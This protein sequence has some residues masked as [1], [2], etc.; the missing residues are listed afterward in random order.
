MTRMIERWFPCA[1]VS[2]RSE[3]G[4]GS[5]NQERALFSWFAARPAAQ[6]KAAVLCSLLPW[7]DSPE[8]QA[9]LR[10][11]VHQ[12]MEDR[13]ASW[14]EV[15]REL[16]RDSPG[17]PAV[18]DPF[19]GRGMIPLEAARLGLDSLAVDYSPVAV[20]ASELLTD[21]PFRD[22]SSE[23]DIAWSRVEERLVDDRPRLLRDVEAVL[24]QVGVRHAAT[25]A[26]FYPV[27][28]GTPPWGYLWAVTLPC[29]ECTRRF[30]LVASLEL[31]K[32]SVRKNR[33]T[34]RSFQDP[35][36]A[37]YLKS[38]ASSDEFQVIVHD[39]PPERAPT[40]ANAIGP[41]G[42]KV[43]GKSATCCFCGH[44]HPL[45]VHQRLAREGLGRDALIAVVSPD[46]LVGRAFR[47]PTGEELVAAYGAADALA[48]EPSFGPG[49]PPLPDEVIPANN[50]ATIRP[51]L[52]GASSYGDLM[53]DRQT[54]STIRLCRAINDVAADL[55]DQGLSGDYRR[56]LIGYAGATLVRVLK[57]S[58]R[59]AKMR[60]TLGAGLVDHIFSNE[61]TVGFSYD[62][63]EV[64]LSDGPGSWP[65]MSASSVSTLRS[66][67]H[68]APPGIPTRVTRGS[69]AALPFRDQAVSAVV[70]DPPYDAMV[71][72]SDSSDL[73][74]AWLKRALAST[75]PDLALSANPDGTQDKSEEIIVKEHGRAPGE[76]RTREHYDAKIAQAFREMRR[77]VRTDGVVTIVFGSGDPVVWQRLL[78]ALQQAD[79]VMTASWPAN[80][81]AGGQQ[82][83]AN[84]ETTLTMACR[85]APPNRIPGRRGAVEAEI[86]AEIKRRY[87]DWERWGLAPADMLMA[88]AGP[89]MEVVG[90]YSEVL[91]SR[92]E[93]VD[94]HTFLPLARTAVQEA[95]AVEIDHRPLET[96]DA[97]T[98]FALWWV[99]L[100]GRQAQP[101]SELRWQVLAFSLD[102]DA[103]RDLVEADKGVAFVTS[104]NFNGKIAADSAVI[105]VALALAAASAQG[106]TAMGEVLAA[107]QFES[108]DQFLWAAVQF[109]AD[110]LPD[111]D[112]D[113]V[114]FHRVLRARAGIGTAAENV[115]KA[116][117]ADRARQDVEDRQIKLL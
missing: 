50:G 52:Y 30:P 100:Y 84:I 21:Y 93:P 74:F 43:K 45:G 53:V 47:A 25:M 58:T 11:L 9:R 28:D 12:A 69:A 56:A 96:F 17:A 35:G 104:S 109:L 4:W 64:G 70:T 110:R 6:A 19:S 26:T 98:R 113:S 103:V 78:S 116:V 51:Q 112:P 7:P 102:L 87:P 20:L 107:S 85:P 61:G 37:F 27:V 1:E 117:R 81:E 22:W 72:Y 31:R 115:A 66:L 49:L 15:R 76:H 48:T 14:S 33:T 63:F 5:G 83:K 8:D 97:R 38:D 99:R 106:L 2:A 88:A 108:D 95:M 89:A 82:G 60:T 71:Y 3:S 44:V 101:K 62:F 32:R 114:A 80:T 54:L 73:F 39:G 77:V 29:Q 86:K 13:Y 57:F 41:D 46:P 90:R 68:A 75:R 24:H 65:A 55:R 36:Q 111:A 23:P 92:G 67:M 42:K 18:L 94:I 59:G 79:L 40:F 105:D 16:L 10:Q 91:D 34:G